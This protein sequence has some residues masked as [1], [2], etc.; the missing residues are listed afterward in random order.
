MFPWKF[1]N[2]NYF[3]RLTIERLQADNNA[4]SDRLIQIEARLKHVL[5]DRENIS[6]SDMNLKSTLSDLVIRISGALST[7]TPELPDDKDEYIAK[8]KEVTDEFVTK[9]NELSKELILAR[10]TVLQLEGELEKKNEK[11]DTNNETLTKLCEELQENKKLLAEQDKTLKEITVEKDTSAIKIEA[12]EKEIEVLRERLT[13]ATSVYD[14]IKEAQNAEKTSQAEREAE[15]RKME[16]E[17][18]VAET[19]LRTTLESLGQSLADPEDDF[20]FDVEKCS[21]ALLKDRIMKIIASHREKRSAVT[22]LEQKV[23]QLTDQ[24]EKQC[25][26]H[27]DTLKRA[28]EAEHRVDHDRERLKNWKNL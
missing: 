13:N 28:R 15:F 16:Y 17:K 23:I 26:L 19:E 1:T 22:V 25:E 18:R 3:Y 9:G 24:L 27:S 11:T 6:A 5:A 14:T 10:A 7:P 2:P 8:I 12:Q 20:E 4:K 21:V